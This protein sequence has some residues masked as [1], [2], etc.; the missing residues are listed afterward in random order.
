VYFSKTILWIEKMKMHYGF[1]GFI[2]LFAEYRVGHEAA[3]LK[4]KMIMQGL[5]TPHRI[6][7]GPK[8][9]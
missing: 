8:A 3:F 1:M 4:S 2:L 7:A 5:T 9:S 6:A